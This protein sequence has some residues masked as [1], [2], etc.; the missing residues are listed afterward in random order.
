V[1][2]FRSLSREE[3]RLGL[4]TLNL[5]ADC[6]EIASAFAIM[7]LVAGG[8]YLPPGEQSPSPPLFLG[9]TGPAV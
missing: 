6:I 5:T 7:A 1:F 9:S 8:L 2:Y 4:T 3:P